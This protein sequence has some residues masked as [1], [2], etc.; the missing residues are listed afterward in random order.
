[1]GKRG[2]GFDR[3]VDERKLTL[4]PAASAWYPQWLLDEIGPPEPMPDPQLTPEEMARFK[5]FEDWKSR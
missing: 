5:S 3:L 2:G 1:M 4:E